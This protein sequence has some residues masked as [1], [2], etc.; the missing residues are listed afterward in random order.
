MQM[1][2]FKASEE[3]TFNNIY[4]LTMQIALQIVT[5]TCET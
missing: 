1:D 2:P 4:L 3:L 5:T